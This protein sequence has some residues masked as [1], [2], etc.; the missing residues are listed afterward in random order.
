MLLPPTI[1]MGATFPLFVQG[2]ARTGGSTTK[3]IGQAYG[4]NV[5]GAALGCG[6]TGAIL[7]G[8][9][10][11]TR[12]VALAV[13]LNVATAAVAWWI[14]TRLSAGAVQPMNW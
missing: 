13:G 11:I 3:T 6:A 4:L 2:L 14:D 8:G 10:G 5:L 7:L 1:L 9:L 12:S